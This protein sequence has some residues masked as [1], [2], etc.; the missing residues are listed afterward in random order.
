[1]TLVSR[2][3]TM[4]PRVPAKE[5][6]LR[7]A[8]LRES[9]LRSRTVVIRQMRCLNIYHYW[10]KWLEFGGHHAESLDRIRAASGSHPDNRPLRCDRVFAQRLGFLE[11]P[12]G[13]E[14]HR[15]DIRRLGEYVQGDG[16]SAQRPL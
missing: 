6:G 9:V 15:A 13:N 1:M 12:A 8:F 3:R 5:P 7:S 11:P 2:Q 10:P 14:P 16:S 4:Y